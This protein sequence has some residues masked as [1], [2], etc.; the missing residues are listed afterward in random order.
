MSLLATN[1]LQRKAPKALSLQAFQGIADRNY[2]RALL[3]FDK[4]DG[5]VKWA[6]C[7]KEL[8]GKGGRRNGE[9]VAKMV[10]MNFYCSKPT[11]ITNNFNG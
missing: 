2:R 5:G 11:A 1:I 3:M 10:P 8:L 9:K 4:G 7:V 6:G